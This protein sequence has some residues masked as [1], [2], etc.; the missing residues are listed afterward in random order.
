MVSDVAARAAPPDLQTLVMPGPVIAG[1]ADVE[2]NCRRCH[3]PFDRRVQRRLCLECHED[4]AAD[5]DR[6]EGFH[7]R[8]LG[9]DPSIECRVCHTEH[10]GRDADVV[11]FSPGSFDH[12]STDFPLEGVHARTAC[13]GCHLPDKKWREAPSR[14]ADCHGKADPHAGG[15]GQKCGDCHDPAGWTKA[16]FDHARTRFPLEGAHARV[17]CALCHPNASYEGTATD[18][19]SCHAV[20]DAHR[21]RFGSDCRSCHSVESWTRAVFDHGIETGFAL[22]G[23]HRKA[24]CAACHGSEGDLKKELP[25][26]CFGCHRNDDDHRGRNGTACGDCHDTSKWASVS[27]D[28][29]RASEFPLRGA[30]QDLDCERCHKGV[31]GHESLSMECVSCHETDDAHRGSLGRDCGKCHDEKSWADRVA[32]D[33]GLTKF[34][35]LGLHAVTPCEECHLGGRFG[36][37][38]IACAECHEDDHHSGR[39]GDDCARCHTPN[40]WRFW[41][42]DHASETTFALHGAHADL[43]C[44]ACHTQPAA[45]NLHTPKNCAACHERDDAH[46]GRLGRRCQS[47]HVETNWKEVT[48]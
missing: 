2:S 6:H 10:K 41:K 30:H 43:D 47:C 31:L 34:P 48:R 19:A 3:E 11:G 15:L 8:A 14:C 7:G 45:G 5:I 20:N 44:H 23:A 35:L 46:S 17:D 13:G 4:V 21:G 9:D 42:F 29:A 22:E 28:H 1:H 33:H 38:R 24:R 12:A 40:G 37:A 18:C 16:R 36:D 39:L 25:K 27:F 32:F 26:D